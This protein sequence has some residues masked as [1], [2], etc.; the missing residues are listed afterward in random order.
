MVGVY[1][2]D[3]MILPPT[4]HN[5][6]ALAVQFFSVHAALWLL[7]CYCSLTGYHMDK[8]RGTLESAL[9]TVQFCPMLAVLMIGLRLRAA[10]M[11]NQRGSPQGWAQEAMYFTTAALF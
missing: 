7:I 11:T 6:M 10:Q 1:T 8:W 5:I 3:S 4:I 2:L 9:V